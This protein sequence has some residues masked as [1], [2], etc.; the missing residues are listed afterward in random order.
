MKRVTVL[1]HRFLATSNTPQGLTAV[2]AGAL[3]VLSPLLVQAQPTLDG[4]IDGDDEYIQLAE[5]TQGDTGFGDHGMNALYGYQDGNTLYV[6]IV[7]EAEDNGNAFLLFIDVSSQSGIAP[8]DSLP[9][10][11]DGLSPLDGYGDTDGGAT[12]DFETD[13]G[14]RISSSDD[15]STPGAFVSIADY[16]SLNDDDNAPETFLEGSLTNGQMIADGTEVTFDDAPFDGTS[17]A[18]DDVDVLSNVTTEAAEFAIPLSALGASSGDTFKL[19]ALYTSGSGNFLSANTLPEI[20]GQGGN[21]LGSPGTVDFS[22]SNFPEDQHTDANPLPVELASFDARRDGENVVLDWKTASET[23]N[24]GFAV[25]HAVGSGDFE[26]IGWVKGAGTTTEAQT[27]R[28]TTENLSAGPHRFRLKQED[29]DG[30]SSLSEVVEVTVR[31]DGPVAIRGVAPNP[32]RGTATLRFTARESG[33][34]TVSLYDVLG[35]K[36]ETLH[37]GRVSGGQPAQVTLNASSLSSGIYFLRVE[38]RSFTRTKRITVA[39]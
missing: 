25:Q 19:F 26:Q 35:R 37:Q 34:V 28:F 16:R 38:G 23:N 13:F 31:P 1:L 20:P 2:L 32:V 27:Y 30:S 24:A 7:G 36:V 3:L 8:G 6:A 4:D 5:W 39:Q 29:L 22:S 33:N 15:G 11:T 21:N 17:I 18:Y 12:H 9:G 10:T 14:V